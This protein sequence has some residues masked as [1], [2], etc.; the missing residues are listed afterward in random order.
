MEKDKELVNT[1]NKYFDVKE[2][3]EFVIKAVET[4]HSNTRYWE[5]DPSIHHYIQ[6]VIQPWF[7]EVG[8]NTWVDDAG[9]L[10]VKM[11]KGKSGKRAINVQYGMAWGPAEDD[12]E[13]A[14]LSSIHEIGEVIKAENMGIPGFDGV[15][16]PG[17][18]STRIRGEVVWGRDGSEYVGSLV[19]AVEAA[20]IIARSGLE[21]P[22]EFAFIVT[23]GGHE[24]TANTI[25]HL[26]HNDEIKA[27]MGV[28]CGGFPII[29]LGGCG[30][31]DLRLTIY[32]EVGHTSNYNPKEWLNAIDGALIAFDR[33]KKIMPFPP[34][35]KDPDLGVGPK[36]APIA[37]ESYPKPPTF[38]MGLGSLGHTWQRMVKIGFDRR[39]IAGENVDDAVKQMKDAI[40][41]LSPFKYKVE[42]SAYH[43]PWKVPRDSP[44]VKTLSNSIQQTSGIKPPLMYFPAVCD[45]EGINRSGIP[46]P[47][48]GACGPFLNKPAIGPHTRNEFT[49]LDWVYG[50][51]KAYAHFAVKSTE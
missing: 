36:L 1:I 10:I 31:I 5:R 25:F 39:V 46:C 45:I 20:R 2:I 38:D 33:L 29:N 21:I 6:R 17:V 37:I 15:A 9:N 24:A 27:D 19:A 13:I 23:A 35:P 26:I 16:F 43:A 4:P 22:G 3:K 42:R 51:A 50:A 18:E 28:S 14:K 32:G 11:G 8:L 49:V 47:S 12:N 40:G 7:E 48:F 41:D 30:R 34:G 44:V